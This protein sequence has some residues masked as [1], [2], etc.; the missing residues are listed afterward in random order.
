MFGRRMPMICGFTAI[1][2]VL[3]MGISLVGGADKVPR[4]TKE[5][6]K[7]MLGKPETVI[8]DVRATGDWD[9]AQMKIKGAAREDPSK[10]TKRWADKYGKDK[11]IILYCA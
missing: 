8:L 10:A 9:K 7:E 11:T 3:T 1:L 4:M 6:L 2:A 5:Q